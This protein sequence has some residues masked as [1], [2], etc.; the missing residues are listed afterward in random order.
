MGE[1][2]HPA[3]AAVVVGN[4][5]SL[6]PPPTTTTTTTTLYQRTAAG[7]KSS[8]PI[9]YQLQLPNSSSS[10]SDSLDSSTTI[11]TSSSSSF[12]ESQKPVKT[13]LDEVNLISNSIKGYQYG[14]T[15]DPVRINSLTEV[16]VPIVWMWVWASWRY[17]CI[18]CA[19]VRSILTFHHTLPAGVSSLDEY[20]SLVLPKRSLPG[21]SL[22][23]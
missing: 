4:P 9:S 6:T 3:Q 10:S 15:V 22:P 14:I 7:M 13:H 23:K 18:F 19:R 1:S 8:N 21:S 11:T 20:R 2:H 12:Q 16:C 5:D 17:I